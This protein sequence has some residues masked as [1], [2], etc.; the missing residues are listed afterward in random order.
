MF[1]FAKNNDMGFSFSKLFNKSESD[2]TSNDSIDSIMEAV[3]QAPF[4][5]SDHNVLYAGFNELGG[6]FF[7][8]TVIIGAFK[9]KSKN[10]GKLSLVGNDFE[11]HVDSDALEFQSNPSDVK[12]RFVTNID[13]QI[14]ESDIEKVRKAKLTEIILKV[15]NQ[16]VLF[17]KY[18][19]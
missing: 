1:S 2:N 15:K 13:F 8:Q 14:E 12:G 11:M 19:Q 10:G 3:E 16:E 5:I 6:Y 18:N 7:L 9:V 4:A 17:K